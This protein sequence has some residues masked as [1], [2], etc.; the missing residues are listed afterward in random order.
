[1]RTSPC[2]RRLTPWCARSSN[3]SRKVVLKISSHRTWAT[4]SSSGRGADEAA[5][6]QRVQ[7][8]NPGVGRR[9]AVHQHN[10]G[11]HGAQ[12]ADLAD[13]P[14]GDDHSAASGLCAN[15]HQPRIVRAVIELPNP[16]G[17]IVPPLK[18]PAAVGSTA[19]ARCAP[20]TRAAPH[21]VAEVPRPRPAVR[22]RSARPRRARCSRRR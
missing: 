11:G 8:E 22:S 21:R 9:P 4:W 12:I 20:A 14:I 17:P 15:R 18:S 16:K 2:H 19:A 10:S 1:M 13:F 7:I 6:H 5:T 3:H